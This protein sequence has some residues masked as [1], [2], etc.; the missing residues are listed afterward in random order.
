MKKTMLATAL[1]LGLVGTSNANE[2]FT[3]WYVGGELSSTKH[4]FS[5]PYSEL[6]Y[7]S[8]NGKFSTNGSRAFGIGVFGGYGFD[9]L[10]DFVGQAELKLRTGGSSTKN[11]LGETVSKEV[12]HLSLAYLQGYRINN[13][14]P[15]IKIGV[16][17]SSFDMNEDAIPMTS[18]RTLVNSGALGFGYG[19]GVKYA[20][21][22]NLEA[23]V[24]YYKASLSGENSLKFKTDIFSLGV[25]YRF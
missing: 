13:I 10:G 12:L 22:P 3:G 15:Y 2:N 4:S 23:G 18:D 7:S 17:G 11:E 5:V 21:N 19:V 25:N 8:I 6:G 20:F 9:F 14:M 16:G 1:L 24:E